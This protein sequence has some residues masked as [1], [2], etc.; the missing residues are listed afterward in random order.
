MC[1]AA[2]R[3]DSRLLIQER[4]LP[5]TPTRTVKDRRCLLSD[6]N[7]LLSTGGRERTRAE[8]GLLLRSARIA[9]HFV[10]NHPPYKEGREPE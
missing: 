6:L 4:V 5:V 9:F 2:M 7:M 8:Y 10:N 1:G 3:P